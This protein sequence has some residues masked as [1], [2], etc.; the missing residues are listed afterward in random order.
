MGIFD[1][2]GW[3]LETILLATL[4]LPGFLLVATTWGLWDSQR[5]THVEVEDEQLTVRR[6]HRRVEIPLTDVQGFELRTQEEATGF[7]EGI[8]AYYTGASSTEVLTVEKEPRVLPVR[9][10]EEHAELFVDAVEEMRVES[11][12]QQAGKSGYR[13]VRVAAT[14]TEPHEVTME[15]SDRELE[16]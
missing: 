10:T 11:K 14:S 7:F 4:A 9:L 1:D 8:W 15:A 3:A 5:S 16:R 6:G 12:R 13:G 2:N